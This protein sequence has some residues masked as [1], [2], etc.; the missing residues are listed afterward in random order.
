MFRVYRHI[1]SLAIYIILINGDSSH[2]QI[3]RVNLNQ[4]MYIAVN[5]HS[6]LLYWRRYMIPNPTTQTIGLY[7]P[8]VILHNINT[9]EVLT[10]IYCSSIS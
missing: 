5:K 6:I 9:S 2:L 1:W 8:V 7:V 4:Y 3:T 10:Y